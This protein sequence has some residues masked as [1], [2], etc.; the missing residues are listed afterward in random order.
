MTARRVLVIEDQPHESEVRAQPVRHHGVTDGLNAEWVLV[1]TSATATRGL[2]HWLAGRL[3][4]A[5]YGPGIRS[6]YGP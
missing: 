6:A 2:A 5:D 3:H 1:A 4:A